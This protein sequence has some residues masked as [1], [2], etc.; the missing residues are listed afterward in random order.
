MVNTISTTDSGFTS[1][2]ELPPPLLPSSELLHYGGSAAAIIIAVA[3]LLRAVGEMIEK[4]VPV[5]LR[6]Q[7]PYP[8]P[9]NPSSTEI[10]KSSSTTLPTKQ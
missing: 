1:V 2:Q 7:T 4:L 3:F 10:D 6:A 5:M 9:S 8:N